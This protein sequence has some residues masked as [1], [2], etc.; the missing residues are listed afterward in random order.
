VKRREFIVGISTSAA[1][2]VAV[3]AQNATIPVIG[4][5][6]YSGAAESSQRVAAFRQGLAEAGFVERGTSQLNFDGQKISQTGCPLSRLIWSVAKS[7][8]S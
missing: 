7:R 3:R 6:D 4:F 2:P 8:S 5:L 1:W